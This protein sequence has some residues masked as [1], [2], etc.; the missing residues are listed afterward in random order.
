MRKRFLS[1]RWSAVWVCVVGV[2]LC[3]T[4][5]A[6]ASP[7]FSIG[8]GQAVDWAAASGSGGNVHP[9]LP[10][11]NVLD[12]LNGQLPMMGFNEAVAVQSQIAPLAALPDQNGTEFDSLVM[13]W[14]NTAGAGL[15]PVAGWEYEYDVDPDLSNAVIDFSLLA[16]PGIW[17]VYLELE[18]MAGL[19]RTWV[20]PTVPQGGLW[21]NYAIQPGLAAAQGPFSLFLETPG[22]DVSTVLKIRLGEAGNSVT[23]PNP[24]GGLP[25]WNAW[26]HL[27]VRPI[28]P[29]PITSTLGV[30]GLGMLGVVTRRRVG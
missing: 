16:P 23:L 28:V 2:G 6:D 21:G 7:Y 1:G 8:H 4:P 22:F 20:L 9:A 25:V 10:G 24:L 26:D 12:L 27:T 5:V 18:D 3:M 11:Q 30:M 19:T 15:L 14:D 17:D 29:E 13:E